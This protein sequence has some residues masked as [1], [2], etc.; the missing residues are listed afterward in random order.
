MVVRR[1]AHL[2]DEPAAAVMGK[3]LMEGTLAESSAAGRWV[4]VQRLLSL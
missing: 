1:G 4:V 2:V 3:G